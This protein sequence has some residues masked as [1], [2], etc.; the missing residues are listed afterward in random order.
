MIP[1]QVLT[2]P[3]PAIQP[4]VPT[5]AGG[6]WAY[7]LSSHRQGFVLDQHATI[8]IRAD[9]STRTDTVSSHAEVSFT[10]TAASGVTGSVVAFLVQNGVQEPS[11][12]NGLVLPFPFRASYSA[13]GTQIDFTFPRD[14]LPCTSTPLA[15]AQSLRD[16][17]FRP[18]DTLRAGVTWEDSASYVLCRDGIPLRATA[19][20]VFRI[21]AAADHDGRTL[22]SISRASRTT[23]EGS[24]VQFGE[25]V[26]VSGSG[27][28]ELVY[29]FDPVAGEIISASGRATTDMSFRSRLRTQAVHQVAEVRL[30][31]S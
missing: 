30:G 17:W 8:A 4:P 5:G 10:A 23:I 22:L 31:R 21:T 6:A 12:P 18:P 26:T 15:V 16:L 19:H 29:A 27:S 24:G 1:N 7:R 11:V 2:K 3:A 9:S 14:D 13:R 20:Q 25:A 28:G